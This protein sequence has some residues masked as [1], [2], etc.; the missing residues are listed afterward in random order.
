MIESDPEDEE[1][2][3]ENPPCDPVPSTSS[4]IP[5][6]QPGQAPAAT[7]NMDTDIS[8][9]E[10]PTFTT[11]DRGPLQPMLS[12]KWD[13]KVNLIGKKVCS[14]ERDKVWPQCVTVPPFSFRW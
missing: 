9:L 14:P 4:G 13:H 2:P 12:L 8:L 11:L 7:Y 6:P 3:Q 1:M 10:A 5:P